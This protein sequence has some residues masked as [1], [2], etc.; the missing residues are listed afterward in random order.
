MT[1]ARTLE[2][3][4]LTLQVWLGMFICMTL[5]RLKR[6]DC[7]R[8]DLS[9]TVFLA[10]LWHQVRVRK[11]RASTQGLRYRCRPRHTKVPLPIHSA[12]AHMMFVAA[13]L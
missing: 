1:T 5:S 12:L 2:G 4:D 7:S 10:I 6:I 9:S 11:R 3:H 8:T 13:G